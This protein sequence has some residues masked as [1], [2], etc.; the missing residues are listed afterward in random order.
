M[1]KATIF[2]TKTALI[3]TNKHITITFLTGSSDCSPTTLT[4]WP[5]AASRQ[6]WPTLRSHVGPFCGVSQQWSGKLL[7]N[8]GTRY[9]KNN[10]IFFLTIL[11]WINWMLNEALFFTW[12]SFRWLAQVSA[13]EMLRRQ[14]CPT[15]RRIK[16]TKKLNFYLNSNSNISLRNKVAV[17][18]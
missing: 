12:L 8:L 10:N 1:L 18:F 13:G 2:T 17:C 15:K 7:E 9:D 5:P 14:A 4:Y 11:T 3:L 16:K 6:T